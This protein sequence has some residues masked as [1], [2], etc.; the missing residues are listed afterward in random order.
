LPSVVGVLEGKESFILRLVYANNNAVILPS[1]SVATV[2]IAA[3]SEVSGT[4]SVMPAS[5]LVYTGLQSKNG[6]AVNGQIYLMR[7]GGMYGKID[8]AWRISSTADVSSI[9]VQSQGLITF[10]DSQSIASIELQ[11][12]RK[13]VYIIAAIVS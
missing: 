2:I 4:V 11:V 8:V 6:T 1:Q 12:T 13:M 3:D 10:E 9:F 5:K 7:T